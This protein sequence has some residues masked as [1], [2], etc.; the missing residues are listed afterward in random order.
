MHSRK[1][2]NM[3]KILII[4]LVL[5]GVVAFAQDAQQ[6][7]QILLSSV[8]Y[9]QKTPLQTDFQLV[10]SNP[11]TTDNQ[12]NKGTLVL[13]GRKFRVKMADIETYFNG[14]TQWV[15]SKENNEVTITEPTPAEL[16]ELNP[17]LLISDCTRTH[18]IAF[19]EQSASD[20]AFWRICLYPLDKNA[21][22]F[23][24]K[25]HIAKKDKCPRSVEIYQKNGDKI[26]F[27]CTSYSV[28]SSL[29]ENA[30]M[31]DAKSHANV[32]VNDLR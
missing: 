1:E 17:L 21:E 7:K 14:K 27:S 15:Y 23:Q 20:K 13:S 30:F 32:E 31:F 28:L 26:N 22:Y 29:S 10:Y 6:A 16:R 5:S 8:A 25:I 11:R 9:I 4:L 24:I 18:R 2:N 19:E 3:K 12:I